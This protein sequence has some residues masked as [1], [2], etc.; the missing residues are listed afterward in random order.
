MKQKEIVFITT[1]LTQTGGLENVTV[2][3]ANELAK[4]KNII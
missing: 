3:L 2:V 4:K 1:N